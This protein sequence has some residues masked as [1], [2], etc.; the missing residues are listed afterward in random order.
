MFFLEILKFKKIEMRL[1]AF[2]EISVGKHHSFR[3]SGGT[4]SVY[5]GCQIVT[6]FLDNTKIIVVI[7]Y[8]IF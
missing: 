4:G 3:N 5:D 7:L 8:K 2:G 1:K 6:I